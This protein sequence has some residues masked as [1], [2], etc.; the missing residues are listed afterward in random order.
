M[1]SRIVPTGHG[2]CR[3]G[4]ICGHGNGA[5]RSEASPTPRAVNYHFKPTQQFWEHFYA[6]PSQ[7]KESVRD[8][9]RIFKANPFDPRLRPHK[10]HRLSARFG[11]T[12]YAVDVE[13]DLRVV[14]YVEGHLVVTVDIGTH[15]IY[16]G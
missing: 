1:D 5:Q 11:R 7:Q 16:R 10:I 3:G 12:I 15:D 2:R 8:A 4:T 9:W 13:A 6:L 14:F